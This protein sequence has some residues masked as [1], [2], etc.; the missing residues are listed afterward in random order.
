MKGL[1]ARVSF[2]LQLLTFA[3]ASFPPPS[4]F[5]LSTSH[6]PLSLSTTLPN[7]PSCYPL[8]ST[9]YSHRPTTSITILHSNQDSTPSL[10]YF[11]L[12]FSRILL[13][14]GFR[15][16][17]TPIL[18]RLAKRRVSRIKSI[19]IACSCSLV[20]ASLQHLCY[21]VGRACRSIRPPAA[22]TFG[23]QP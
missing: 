7:C 20:T 17:P 15:L 6:F 9:F 4:V 12:I 8:L 23:L 2:W 3:G 13:H 21:L 22:S 16:S 14:T 11:G 19:L 18:S 1:E 5:P 10:Q